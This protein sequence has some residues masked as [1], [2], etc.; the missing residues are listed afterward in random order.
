MP[1]DPSPQ[2]QTMGAE[3]IVILRPI[4]KRRGLELIYETGVYEH[5]R[6]P[7]LVA[8]D[9]KYASAR[10]IEGHAAL[11]IEILSP[12]D[13]SRQKVAFYAKVGVGEVWIVDHALRTVEVYTLRG[14]TY[15]AV[16]P[17]RDG[18]VHAPALGVELQTV[19]GPKLR[20]SWGDGTSEI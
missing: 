9:P 17:D 20:I 16:A 1:P 5:Y 14:D 19:A 7:D 13:E 15:F 4:A 2:H 8:F 11:V 12:N 3:L 18:V 6:S 10:G